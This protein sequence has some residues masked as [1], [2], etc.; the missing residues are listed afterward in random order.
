MYPSRLD[1]RNLSDRSASRLTWAFFALGLA[2]SIWMVA[3]SQV[4]G[5]Q[6][7]LLARGWLLADEGRFISYGNPMSTGGKAPGGITSLLVGLPLMVWRDH[8]APTLVILVCHVLAFLIL[9][10]TLRRVFGPRER[11]LFA[12]LYWLNPW[13]MY[14]SAF[15]WNPNYLFL[16]GA[17]HLWACWTQRERARFLPSFLLG[18]GLLLAFQIHASFLLLAVSS[19]LLWWRGYFKPHWT[20]GSLGAVLAA[21]P[22]VPWVLDLMQQPAI[23]TEADKGFLG[24]GLVYVFPLLRGLGYWFRYSSLAVSEKVLRFDFGDFMDPQTGARLGAGVE[25]VASAVLPFTLLL[26]LAAN[27][28]LWRWMRG[29]WRKKLPVGS[30][31]RS[32]LKRYALWT[33]VG[34]AAVFALSPTTIMM[35]QALIVL[36][37]AVLPLVLWAGVLIRSRHAR[38]ATRGL[39]VYATASVL[40]LLLI[41]LG[42]THY[43]CAGHD[44]SDSFGLDLRHDHRMLH[45]LHIHATCPLPVNRPGGWWPDVLPEN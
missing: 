28:R 19:A 1:L 9:D 7:N 32:W 33:F 20:G 38:R 40:L 12:V 18:A 36:H 26:P 35:W 8:R 39:W 27:I 30:S 14:F 13:R 22:L 21:L 43:R 31:D 44:G 15:L 17:V 29:R 6:L 2:I 42:S 3:R 11:V 41:P 25:D 16:A 45:E 4:G 5:D 10:R 23:L 34:A 37:A 24:R